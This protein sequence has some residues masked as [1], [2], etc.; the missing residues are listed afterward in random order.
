MKLSVGQL[1]LIAFLCNLT[2]AT[3]LKGQKSENVFEVEL[4]MSVKDKSI[5]DVFL[6]IESRTKFKFA[7]DKKILGNKPNVTIDEI[8]LG[9]VLTS[10]SDQAQLNFRQVN[11]VIAV[12]EPKGKETTPVEVVLYDKNIQGKV[13]DESGD[14]LIGATVRVQ[15]TQIGAITDL[16]GNFS[17]SV[18]DDAEFL[19]VSYIGFISQEILIGGKTNFEIE[20]KSD[21]T[22][23]EEVVV[24]GYGAQKKANLTGAV[25]KVEGDAI[26]QRPITQGS[27]A[28]QGLTPG[29]FINSNS[30]E[31]GNDD[32]SVTIR[33]VGTFNNT[34]P[35]VIIDGIEGSLD[36]IN[37]HD[38]ESI[39]VLKDAASAS[40]YGTRAANGVII[41]KTKRG[42]VGKPTISYNNSFSTTE[43]TIL[44]D[45]VYDTRTYLEAYVTAAENSNRSHPFTPELIDE[46]SGLGST[47]WLD[48]F[49]G[50]GMVLF[51]TMT[52][53]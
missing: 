38:I 29:I 15:G 53:P 12:T 37:P 35:L 44:P 39:N 40:I 7:L 42:A 4:E 20:L 18:P 24:V 34:E 32:A 19:Q 8:I 46:L 10:I 17:L 49:V 48:E 13:T 1:F 25:A 26:N 2:F 21:A 22:A 43:P 23:L 36:N 9:K 33:G 14:P 45:Y 3:D 28:L 30:G 6:D 27:Q 16:D 41:V 47:N 52:Y 11:D 31:P 5:L 50:N 51:R